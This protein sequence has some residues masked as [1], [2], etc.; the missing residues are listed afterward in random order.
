MIFDFSKLFE[1]AK[2]P[3][4]ER[5]TLLVK[6]MH[7]RIWEEL[8]AVRGRN[9]VQ[10]APLIQWPAWAGARRRDYEIHGRDRLGAL[11]GRHSPD[12]VTKLSTILTNLTESAG[13]EN[14][15]TQPSPLRLLWGRCGQGWS[16]YLR[17]KD[18]NAAVGVLNRATG[19]ALDGA[20]RQTD[21][22]SAHYSK[23]K[24]CLWF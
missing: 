8:Y 13:K 5:V 14:P 18:S 6:W 10:R 17:P 3:P 12:V 23:I 9:N 16:T 15:T 7:A 21:R 24:L 22:L 20:D 4:Y 11:S 19:K 2:Y 1:P